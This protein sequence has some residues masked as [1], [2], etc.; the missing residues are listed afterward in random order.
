MREIELKYSGIVVGP[1]SKIF[2]YIS[3]VL[4]HSFMYK[5]FGWLNPKIV[6]VAENNS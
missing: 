2:S 3:K 5:I 6:I 4:N 1:D